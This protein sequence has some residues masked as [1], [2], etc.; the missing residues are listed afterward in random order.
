MSMDKKEKTFH[1]KA[2]M[3]KQLIKE[4]GLASAYE[5]DKIVRPHSEKVGKRVGHYYTPKQVGIILDLVQAHK[6]SE[7]GD[8]ASL[9]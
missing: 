1:I 2:Y 4:L 5:F 3:K 7:A 6:K 8:L 9:N